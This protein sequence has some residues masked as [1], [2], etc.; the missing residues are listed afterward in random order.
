MYTWIRHWSQTLRNPPPTRVPT[1]FE[2]RPFV[3]VIAYGADSRR[4]QGRRGSWCYNY[5]HYYYYYSRTLCSRA[6]IFI[7][8]SFLLFFFAQMYSY[9]TLSSCPAARFNSRFVFQFVSIRFVTRFQLFPG[10]GPWV[11]I[12]FCFENC[13]M[14]TYIGYIIPFIICCS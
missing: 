11:Q 6:A 1:V 12:V 5:H 4:S 7:G 9:D 14:F 3:E 8:F 2:T 13:R 10:M